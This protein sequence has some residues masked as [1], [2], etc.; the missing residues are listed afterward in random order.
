MAGNTIIHVHSQILNRP[1][2]WNPSRSIKTPQNEGISL[3]RDTI[4]MHGLQLPIIKY[5]FCSYIENDV[6]KM[7]STIKFKIIEC[8][9]HHNHVEPV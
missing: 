6:Q 3:N 4:H 2:H 9:P 8:I 1:I 5:Y 7:I